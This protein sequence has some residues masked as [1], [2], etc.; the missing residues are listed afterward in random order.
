MDVNVENETTTHGTPANN[1]SAIFD[2]TPPNS[3]QKPLKASESSTAGANSDEQI[4]PQRA[5]ELLQE[6]NEDEEKHSNRSSTALKNVLL[7]PKD[8]DTH[9]STLSK[10]QQS[11]LDPDEAA[12]QDSFYR[13]DFHTLRPTFNNVEM[14]IRGVDEMKDQT[15]LNQLFMQNDSDVQILANSFNDTTDIVEYFPFLCFSGFDVKQNTK[16]TEIYT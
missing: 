5:Q 13:K 9:M 6:E 1:L 15:Q 3:D 16:Y 8:A 2:V 10:Q 14:A 4:S 12:V 7:G 11:W